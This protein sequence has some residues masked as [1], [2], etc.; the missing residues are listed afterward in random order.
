MQGWYVEIASQKMQVE[1][2]TRAPDCLC[3]AYE[4]HTPSLSISYGHRTHFHFG[5]LEPREGIMFMDAR[6][7]DPRSRLLECVTNATETTP[8][9]MSQV[10]DAAG[11]RLRLFN[12]GSRV[13]Q[14][15]NGSISAGAWLDAA[16]LL[17]AIERP[18]WTMRRL[19][20]DD[21][22]WHCSLSRTPNIPIEF[23]DTIESPHP[24]PALAIVLGILA[25]REENAAAIPSNREA[26]SS[27]SVVV[28]C[29][30]NFS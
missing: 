7:Y 25:E 27:G 30:D 28:A 2:N 13:V 15:L 9:L 19:I 5:G 12:R 6:I 21:G 23:D 22:Q 8:G 11:A 29:C 20:H 18:G 16:L 24:D 1:R 3:R 10:V 26:S 4:R 17:L 14:Q